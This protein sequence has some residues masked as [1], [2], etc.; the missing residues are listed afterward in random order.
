MSYDAFASFYDELTNDVDYNVIAGF[1]VSTLD[2]YR[3]SSELVVDLA[4]G[5]GTLTGIL[6][7]R[8][9]DMIGIDASPDMLMKAREKCPANVLLLCQPMNRLDL[10]GTIDAV[11]CTLDSISHITDADTLLEVFKN[12]SL[13][14]EDNGI[15]VFDV[16]TEY[17]HRNVLAD[18][19]FV[20]DSENVYC[21]WQNSLDDD[22]VNINLDFFELDDGCYYRSSEAF[23]ERAY[24]DETLRK[25]LQ[26]ADLTV[27]AVMDGYTDREVDDKSERA[28][29][30]TKRMKRNG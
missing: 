8:G 21:V 18:N 30:I 14:L 1:I 6:A 9:Y 28:V 22:V 19:T 4:C 23:S 27:L 3:P 2:K 24:S 26:A 7:Q 29:Y 10:Y 15:F 20:I 13:F 5:T 16:N 12:V 11:V 25:M 17:K